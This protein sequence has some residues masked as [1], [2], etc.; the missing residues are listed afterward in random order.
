MSANQNWVE[1]LLIL[2]LQSR[3]LFKKRSRI[4]PITDLPAMTKNQIPSLTR[5]NLLVTSVIMT[6]SKIFL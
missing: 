2:I 1:F 6:L 5:S 4:T 3:D